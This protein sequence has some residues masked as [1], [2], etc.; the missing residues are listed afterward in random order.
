MFFSP[1]EDV[2]LGRKYAPMIE[3]ELG[4]R[5]PDENLQSY[6]NQV[7]QRIARV[8]HRPDLAYHFGAVDYEGANALAMPGGYIYITKGLLTELQSEAQLAAVLGHEVGH[9]VARDTMAAISRQI[10]MTALLAAASVSDAPSDVT[11]GTA[12][13]TSMLSL[14]YSREDEKDADFTGLSY[15]IQAGYDPNGM[16]ETMEVLQELQTVRPIEFFSTHPNPENRMAY[17][18]ERITRRYADAGPL[19]KGEE[20]YAARVVAPLKERKRALKIRAPEAP[21]GK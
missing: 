1:D 17:L 5:I 3:K 12:F 15:M 21:G 18:K 4:G 10:G 20:E 16:V 9:V 2:K 11:R 19:K 13:V 8:C 14:Q 7:G 6:I